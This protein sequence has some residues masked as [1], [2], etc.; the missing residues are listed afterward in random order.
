MANDAM[1]SADVAKTREK[2]KK[3]HSAKAQSGKTFA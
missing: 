3:G 1:F 2:E